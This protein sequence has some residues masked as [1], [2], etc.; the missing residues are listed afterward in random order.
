[1]KFVFCTEPI[2]QYYRSYLY[3]DD[4]DK[5][6]KQL[7]IEYGDYKDIWDLK[8]Q[9]DAL[10][11]NIFV[12]ELTSRDYPR[13]PWNYV[14]QL[15]SKLTY[16]YLIDSPDFETIFSEVLFNQSEMEFYEFYKAIYRFYNG[17]EVFIIVS[18][19]EYSDMVTQMMYNVLRRTYGIHPQIIY[20]MDDVN[21]IR[22]DIDFSPQ[23]AQLAY[24]QRSAY[25]KLDSKK[26]FEPLQIWYPFDMN[27]YTNALE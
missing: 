12:A 4:K 8:Q 1:M 17:S 3:A 13:N 26:D 22:D 9:Q 25:F 7:M 11:E 20:D 10:P 16:Q 5:L 14:S 23:G 2:Y 27:T 6:D 19:D 24:L 21:S 18:D 15:I